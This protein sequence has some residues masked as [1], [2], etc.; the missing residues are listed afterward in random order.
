MGYDLRG[1]KAVVT[2]GAQGLGFAIAQALSSSGCAV[3]LV[4]MNEKRLAEAVKALGAGSRSYVCD[5]TS[6]TSVTET[7]ERIAKEMGSLDILVNNAGIVSTDDILDVAHESWRKI[8]D[9][10]LTGSFYFTQAAAKIMVRQGRGGRIVN[11]ASVAGRN[12]GLQTSPAYSA[13]KAGIIGL[14]KAAA[15]QLAKHKITVNAVAPGSLDSEMLRGFGEEKFEA[16]K[17]GMP[18]GR[19]GTFE[20]VANAVVFL[21]S[22]EAEFVDGVCLDVNGGQ[23]MA[24]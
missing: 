20:D 1:R 24:T 8:I 14:T 16:L 15:R 2:G 13:S 18:L 3:A 4:D 7:A 22:A 23:Y 9:V 11:I 19:L 5:V 6:G 17:K 21:A 10:N 12:G